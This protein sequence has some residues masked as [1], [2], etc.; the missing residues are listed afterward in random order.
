MSGT[1]TAII[2]DIL[3]TAG[4]SS[5]NLS[6]DEAAVRD[7]TQMPYAVSREGISTAN[8]SSN[9]RDV[10]R[11][12][13]LVQIDLKQNRAITPD[14]PSLMKRIR[15]ALDAAGPQQTTGDNAGSVY[16]LRPEGSVRL[17]DQKTHIV[18]ES[19]TV[20]VTRTA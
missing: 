14:D 1:I 2:A 4:L 13:E 16:R 8:S 12:V 20:R 7:T 11:V 17:Y 5:L 9:G 3:D 15:A 18:T 19:L 10:I 6:R